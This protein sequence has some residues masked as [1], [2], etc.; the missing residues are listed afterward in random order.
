VTAG[1]NFFIVGAGKA[2]TTSLYRYL[3]QHPQI[4]MSPIKEPSYF[5]SEVRVENLS[6]AFRRHVRRQSVGMSNPLGW[7]VLDGD[8]YQRLFADVKDEIA[9]GEATPTYLW[10]ETAAANIHARVPHARIILML[11]DPAERAFSQYLHQLAE[12]LTRYTFREQIEK[13]ARGG[14]RELSILHP[15]LEIGLYYQQVKRY[16]AVFPR[17]QMRIYWYEEA[18]RQPARLLKDIFEFLQVD[19]AFQP[20]FSERILE[21]RAPRFKVLGYLRQSGVW[22]SVKGRIPPRLRATL[23]ALTFQHGKTLTMD[24]KD[25]EY[26]IAYYRRDIRNLAALLDKD[27]SAWLR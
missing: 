19:A 10:S 22:Q 2:G 14:N 8:D 25:R 18:W 20:D 27:L 9:I 21:R 23:R 24:P 6:P 13:S 26:L 7:L 12:G 1:P 11:R 17:E 4:Y 5:A 16:L 3:K 15:F